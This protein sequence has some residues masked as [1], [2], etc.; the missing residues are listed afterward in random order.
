MEVELGVLHEGQENVWRYPRPSLARSG[1]SIAT[2][3][4]LLRSLALGAEKRLRESLWDELN[5]PR[6]IRVNVNSDFGGRFS[7]IR[8]ANPY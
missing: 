2:R 4:L 1:H 6:E 8:S 5:E 3:R 7:A